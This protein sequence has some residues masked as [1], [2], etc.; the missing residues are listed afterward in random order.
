MPNVPNLLV[1]CIP[2]ATANIFFLYGHASLSGQHFLQ[3]TKEELTKSCHKIIED[4]DLIAGS[5]K[6]EGKKK[7]EA[8]VPCQQK[9]KA[10]QVLEG[11]GS[12]EPKTGCAV[13]ANPRKFEMHAET[14]TPEAPRCMIPRRSQ[15]PRHR[16]TE[17]LPCHELHL[18]VHP[19]SHP[20]KRGA[21]RTPPR[22]PKTAPHRRDLGALV[23]ARARKGQG[24][25]PAAEWGGSGGASGEGQ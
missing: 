12:K 15:P 24:Q 21:R 8:C 16:A 9:K 7:N 5:K 20:M 11:R 3:E 10:I 14:L 18:V 22:V 1:N 13:T 25:G 2:L 23:A 4:L 6:M 19:P 17:D